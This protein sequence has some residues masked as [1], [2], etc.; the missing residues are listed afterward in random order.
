MKVNR[1]FVNRQREDRSQ[2]YYD[3]QALP[4]TAGGIWN[5]DVSFFQTVQNHPSAGNMSVAGQLP[6]PKELVVRAITVKPILAIIGAAGTTAA[7]WLPVAAGILLTD[8]VTLEA[9]GGMIFYIADKEYLRLPLYM[10][11]AGG[12]GY[13]STTAAGAGA[14]WGTPVSFNRFKLNIPLVIPMQQNF[15]ILVP[16]PPI[17]PVAFTGAGADTVVLTIGLHGDERR[18]VQ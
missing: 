10:V 9:F 2:P 4:V 3:K 12:G 1:G 17:A 5:A 14:N 13:F 8:I 16:A 15:R 11:P 7:Q 18:A 6:A